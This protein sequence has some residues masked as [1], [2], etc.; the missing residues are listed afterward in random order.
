MQDLELEKVSVVAEYLTKDVSFRELGQKYGVRYPTIHA[1]VQEFKSVIQPVS[2]KE[3]GKRKDA[4]APPGELPTDIQQ[5]QKE[6][7]MARLENQLLNAI[8]NIAEEQLDIDIRKKSG[9]KPSK[10]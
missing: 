1:W 10:K 3:K 4:V 9:T 8:I 5:L 6:L 2:K 7:E